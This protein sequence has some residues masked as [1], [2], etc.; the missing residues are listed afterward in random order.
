MITGQLPPYD[1][2]CVAQRAFP[3]GR[4]PLLWAAIFT[5]GQKC[6]GGFLIMEAAAWKV[7]TQS[8]THR[9][10]GNSVYIGKRNLMACGLDRNRNEIRLELA[11]SRSN[12]RP[13][14]A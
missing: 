6:P 14:S 4:P 2:L 9:D 12:D 13:A 8:L 11:H 5:L 7:D 1:D 3:Q 10:G